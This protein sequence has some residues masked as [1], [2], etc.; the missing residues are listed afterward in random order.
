MSDPN[1]IK[2]AADTP[3]GYAV[4]NEDDFDAAL[5]KRW[6]PEEPESEKPR[7]GRPPK[8]AELNEG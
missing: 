7:R 4:I 2:V 3:S 6:P 5:H 8:E 1:T